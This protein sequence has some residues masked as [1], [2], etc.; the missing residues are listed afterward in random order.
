M[1]ALAVEDDQ[2]TRV[3]IEAH[4]ERNGWHVYC[5]DSLSDGIKALEAA[6]FDCIVLDLH[7]PDAAGMQTLKRM[8]R[9]A[10]GIPVV[11]L[12]GMD[13]DG[14]GEKAIMQGAVDFVNKSGFKYSSLPRICNY[15]IARKTTDRLIDKANDILHVLK[16]IDGRGQCL[17]YCD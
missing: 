15:A 10:R 2:A 11:V 17:K 13:D 7:L 14:I 16:I 4:L 12:T 1:Y 8:L 5:V 3:M 6:S 9:V